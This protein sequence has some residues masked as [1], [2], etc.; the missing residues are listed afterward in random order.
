MRRA[1]IAQCGGPTAVLNASL[2]GFV[3]VA[4]SA[5][6]V[7]GA[8]GGPHGLLTGDLDPIEGDL[9]QIA[10]LPGAWLGAGR[11][12]LDEVERER[13]IRELAERNVTHLALAGGN[14][15]MLLADRIGEEAAARG[16][17]LRVVGIPKTVDNDLFGTDHC[18]GY[19]SAARFL[20]RSV[21]DMALDHSAFHSIEPVRIVETFGRDAGWLAYAAAASKREEGDAPHL[22]YPPEQGYDEESFLVDVES[23]VDAR[24]LA[25]VV[26][27]EGFAGELIDNAFKTAVFD[28]P[29][30]GGVA[31]LLADVVERRLG[32]R[33]RAD[34]LGTVQRCASYAV[35][36]LDR[37][38]AREAGHVAAELLADGVSGVMVGIH[39][40]EGE[41]Y[42]SEMVPVP[43]AEVGGRNRRL[44]A[45]WVVE[46][47]QAPAAF[48]RW[49][50]PL[51][52]G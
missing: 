1:V 8:R 40:S 12:R 15:T 22:V 9:D 51:I 47:D 28:R 4:C 48:Q 39:R 3:E 37:E 25:T 35:S 6:E 2:A 7:L 31:R 24:G 14:G 5:F 11:L 19:P 21:R 10:Q 43:L 33:T 36:R 29:L 41:P 27:A 20:A 46:P 32:L 17:E 52:A 34:V 30:T 45:E 23:S 38:E 50:K 44:P 13:V 18:P 42:R 16:H 26:V 49:L